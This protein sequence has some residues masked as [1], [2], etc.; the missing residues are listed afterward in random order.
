[1]RVIG[2]SILLVL[3]WANLVGA[4]EP[5]HDPMRDAVGNAIRNSMPAEY[6]I[7]RE[8]TLRISANDGALPTLTVHVRPDGTISLPLLADVPAAGFTAAELS[9][10]LTTKLRAFIPNPR[11]S[12]IV[13]DQRSVR[14]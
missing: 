12:V 8:D 2:L 14:P 9:D 6:R 4:Q 7:G 3:A 13:L 5:A 10:V 1:M 11:P